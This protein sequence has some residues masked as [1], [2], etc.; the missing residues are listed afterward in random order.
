[1]SRATQITDALLSGDDFDPRDYLLSQRVDL[2]RFGFKK[3]GDTP[4]QW[5]YRIPSEDVQEDVTFGVRVMDN[6][7]QPGY[8]LSFWLPTRAIRMW[9]TWVDRDF[10]AAHAG[11]LIK[12]FVTS[13]GL[14]GDSAHA[15]AKLFGESVRSWYSKWQRAGTQQESEE[16][17]DARGYFLD[18][19][20]ASFLL[21][22]G[23]WEDKTGSIPHRPDDVP[24]Y[25]RGGISVREPWPA[26]KDYHQISPE[27]WVA[28]I[29]GYDHKDRVY[30]KQVRGTEQEIK[31][32]LLNQPEFKALMQESEDFDAAEYL[33]TTPEDIR[34]YLKRHK[35]KPNPHNNDTWQAWAKFTKE[36]YLLVR[37]V[38][39]G[40]GWMGQISDLNGRGGGTIY[41]DKDI[42]KAL[43]A[44]P[45]LDTEMVSE[46]DDFDPREYVL[47]GEKLEQALEASGFRMKPNPPGQTEHA[48]YERIDSVNG[49]DGPFEQGDTMWQVT[50][51]D[52]DLAILYRLD[53]VPD[54]RGQA[55]GWKFPATGGEQRMSH[56]QLQDMLS[57]LGESQDFD[58][59]DYLTHGGEASRVIDELY[60]DGWLQVHNSKHKAAY[61]ILGPRSNIN[62]YLYAWDEANTVQLHISERTAGARVAYGWM[63]P[64]QVLPVVAELQ[65]VISMGGPY[66][67]MTAAI[68]E[69]LRT[70]DVKTEGYQYEAEEEPF[71]AREYLTRRV[72]AETQLQMAG[73]V[74]KE[75]G[76]QLAD[77]IGGHWAFVHIDPMW[78]LA[79]YDPQGTRDAHR[80]GYL[81]DLLSQVELANSVK[82]ENADDFDARQYMM[83]LPRTP[84]SERKVG[85]YF[86]TGDD[87]SVVA[88]KIEDRTISPGRVRLVWTKKDG[89][90]SA[91]K[92]PSHWTHWGV[93]DEVGTYP[94]PPEFDPKQVVAESVDD[95]DA[96]EYMLAD[97][98][99]ADLRAWLEAQGFKQ[100]K[101]AKNE[102]WSK[103]FWFHNSSAR[104]GRHDRSD[105]G[106]WE[107]PDQP[108]VWYFQ[109]KDTTQTRRSGVR[110]E[111]IQQ[112]HGTPADILVIAKKWVPG[113]AQEAKGFDARGYFL[114]K[115]RQAGPWP[116]KGFTPNGP[117]AK[118][119]YESESFKSADGRDF[120]L[121]IH[122]Y[123]KEQRF[124]LSLFGFY[125]GHWLDSGMKTVGYED[126]L[127]GYIEAVKAAIARNHSTRH[128]MP[129]MPDLTPFKY[130]EEVE[131]ELDEAA[132]LPVP[133]DGFDA[134]DYIVG[135]DER[136]LEQTL[137]ARGFKRTDE[138]YWIRT[139]IV[140]THSGFF[141]H[142]FDHIVHKEGTGDSAL[143]IYRRYEM[144]RKSGPGG[145]IDGK[146]S[147]NPYKV[148]DALETWD[149]QK[150]LRQYIQQESEDFDARDYLSSMKAYEG[151]PP[152]KEYWVLFK[153]GEYQRAVKLYKFAAVQ[154][155]V[156]DKNLERDPSLV[157]RVRGQDDEARDYVRQVDGT[158]EPAGMASYKER[159]VDP[160]APVAESEEEENILQYALTT[161]VKPFGYVLR[162]HHMI[163]GRPSTTPWLNARAQRFEQAIGDA[164]VF[165]RR[166]TAEQWPDLEIVPIY[167]DPRKTGEGALDPYY[168]PRV[169]TRRAIPVPESLA[170]DIAKE[171][172]KAEQPKSEEQAEAGN[173]K[174]G[175]VHLHGFEIAIEN[176]KGS[177]RKSKDPENPWQVTMPAHYGYIKGTVG[178]DKDHL[179]VYIGEHPT[180]MLAFV[181][182]QKKK[183][184]GFDEHKIMLGF[185]SKDEAVET[186]DKAF[187]GDLGPKLRDEVF[188]VT[189]DQLKHWIEKG[190]TKK[191]FKKLDETRAEFITRVLLEADEDFDAREYVLN[192]PGPDA[193]LRVM[194]KQM[195]FKLVKERR[196]DRDPEVWQ[197]RLGGIIHTV[198]QRGVGYGWQYHRNTVPDYNLMTGAENMMKALPRY[199]KEAEEPFDAREYFTHERYRPKAVN[200]GGDLWN[201]ERRLRNVFSWLTRI[202]AAPK[203]GT[204]PIHY[205][206]QDQMKALDAIID[207]A[208]RRGFEPEWVRY[209]NG[210]FIA[211][212]KGKWVPIARMDY[213]TITPI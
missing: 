31:K 146:V 165:K 167:S 199:V 81:E 157:L 54:A 197:V 89:Y 42:I 127:P 19:G 41:G 91:S 103:S 29:Q 123:P 32:W 95:F 115:P 15:M 16:A 175:H 79:H 106:I 140:T 71:D 86:C 9:H 102:S 105:Y 58:A 211:H 161:P 151:P 201:D 131:A 181:V 122:V 210:K 59:R 124:I 166:R 72:P 60:K 24:V 182:N 183:E 64:E 30:N 82:F 133:T 62:V 192:A 92:R 198:E 207:A 99:L 11:D 43:D 163:Q 3:L 202:G 205:Y 129:R 1:M 10:M 73:A 78:N 69:V 150:A 52:K 148:I 108:G 193:E 77:P 111:I 45:D 12:E 132:G 138:D 53:Y 83:D 88:Q 177:V 97:Q 186:Y 130:Q 162:Y 5:S 160:E 93:G 164:T 68:G 85:E 56:A 120:K 178:K 184:G 139:E 147:G 61:N 208:Q 141:W 51:W 119:G 203:F 171:A 118:Y 156:H 168:K 33:S 48:M 25:K 135:A 158:Y 196:T 144:E 204:L 44:L 212:N 14:G 39:Q 128:E 188:S 137:I 98:G 65:K 8:L 194:L 21:G 134:R 76:W 26:Q 116:P 40:G 7:G 35:F 96:R 100:S 190:D 66:N 90:V 149:K 107:A 28:T 67:Q 117:R 185:K 22:H 49:E 2:S 154:R 34:E 94:P 172:E 213:G 70:N 37:Y 126:D 173:Q 6:K 125:F 170:D 200:I 152:G 159:F 113:V 17:F 38:W 206:Q 114:S 104:S 87:R 57:T 121:N 18:Q 63:R 47:S 143:W 27:S 169:Y 84:F 4:E 136:E 191:P 75:W 110:E 209:R 153:E 23:F 155:F 142:R 109:R 80:S 145:H 101:T 179:D 74:K 20:L 50:V 13:V 36:H 180:A 46:A 189:I 174:K 112:F 176:A 187:T 195:G 55:W